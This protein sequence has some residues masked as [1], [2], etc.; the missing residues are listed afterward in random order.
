MQYSKEWFIYNF[1]YINRNAD[2]LRLQVLH[3]CDLLY[4]NRNVQTIP[5]YI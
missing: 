4:I 5:I 2:I 3:L 1:T